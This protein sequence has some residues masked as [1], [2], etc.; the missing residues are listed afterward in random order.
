MWGM[1][2]PDRFREFVVKD[3][4]VRLIHAPPFHDRVVH[5][6]LVDVIEPFFEKKF[7]F[8][9]YA[10]RKGKG[11]HMAA[12]KAQSC[13]RKLG[14]GKSVY[15]LKADISKYF[16]SINHNHLMKAISRTIRDKN[17]LSLSK[18]IIKNS[19]F[20]KVGLPVGTLTS[21]LFANV[22]L[23]LFDHYIKDDLGVKLY[24]RYMDDF[25]VV[26]SN[27]QDL[28]QIL[29]M[30]SNFLEKEL[31]LSL[32]PKTS[33]FPEKQGLDFC[34]YR[35]WRTHILPRKRTVK[36]AR[37]KII[38][39]ARKCNAG[40]APVSLVRDQIMSYLGYM[41]HCNG[42]ITS[43][44][45]LIDAKIKRTKETT[46]WR[47]TSIY[48]LTEN[49]KRRQRPIVPWGSIGRAWTRSVGGE[50]GLEMA[51]TT[52]WSTTGGCSDQDAF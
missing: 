13:I 32:N 42:H 6:A 37:R 47:L 30:A 35:I 39:T 29:S 52:L 15:I 17:V 4:K 5:H 10:C 20:D 16:P 31:S 44:H 23:D 48:S 1:W 34:G 38:K 26:S 27:K 36:R 25:I 28:H 12:K 22:Y 19:G 11:F 49:T 40:S 43:K 45:I 24:C 18:N 3:P 14:A 9:S 33:I 41:K 2:Q 51:T 21:Q 50:G 46:A 7:I 8:D